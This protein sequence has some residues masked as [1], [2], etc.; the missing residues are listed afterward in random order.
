M[1]PE[2][3]SHGD[4]INEGL[5]EQGLDYDGMAVTAEWTASFPDGAGPSSATVSTAKLRCV[6]VSCSNFSRL[7]A[8]S[9]YVQGNP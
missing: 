1:Q 5:E 7:A 3:R 2:V 8:G 9:S 4:V 6:G